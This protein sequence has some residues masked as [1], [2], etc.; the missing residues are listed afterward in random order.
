M[1]RVFALADIL[2][3]DKVDML[4]L[5]RHIDE[6]SASWARQGNSRGDA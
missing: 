6:P 5:K 3:K 4:S 1:Q 2:E